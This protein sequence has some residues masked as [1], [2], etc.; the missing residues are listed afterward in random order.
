[1]KSLD[2]LIEWLGATPKVAIKKWQGG[3]VSL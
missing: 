3:I 2:P 1:M